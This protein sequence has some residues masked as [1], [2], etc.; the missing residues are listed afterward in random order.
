[1]LQDLKSL[2][3]LLSHLPDTEDVTAN[4]FLPAVGDSR[5]GWQYTTGLKFNCSSDLHFSFLIMLLVEHLD[6]HE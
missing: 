3:L 2:L 1:M 6:V 4:G 5:R